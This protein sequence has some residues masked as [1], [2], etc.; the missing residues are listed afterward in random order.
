MKRI[1]IETLDE[2]NEWSLTQFIERGINMEFVKLATDRYMVKGTNGYIVN[3]K[4]K[5]EMEK[6]ELAMKD[7]TSKDCQSETTKKIKKINKRIKE[8]E[9]KEL[10]VEQTG[11]EVTQSTE[12]KEDG[13]DDPIEETSTVI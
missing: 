9:E 2:R 6:G 12:E 3:E 1:N 10:P 7:I 4:E 11:E 13:V 5:L 8:I